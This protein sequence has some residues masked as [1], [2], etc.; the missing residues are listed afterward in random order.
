MKKLLLVICC[1]LSIL[2][3]S[4]IAQDSPYVPAGYVKTFSDEFDGIA[5]NTNTWN[6]RLGAYAPYSVNQMENVV[7]EDGK[8]NIIQDE[9]PKPCTWLQWLG[10]R[11]VS[12][13]QVNNFGDMAFIGLEQ[14]YLEYITSCFKHA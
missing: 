3:S 10:K 1:F 5:V 14:G 2:F 4:A 11:G 7:I 13:L 9:H 8:M 12:K 6:Y